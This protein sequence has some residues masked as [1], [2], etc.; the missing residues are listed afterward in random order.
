MDA[1]REYVDETC[2]TALESSYETPGVDTNPGSVESNQSEQLPDKTLATPNVNDS[3]L[4]GQLQITAP[5]KRALQPTQTEVNLDSSSWNSFSRC[6]L[7]EHDNRRCVFLVG[8]EKL[9]NA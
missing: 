2:D 3:H 7:S 6:L 9:V 1:E 8:C 5:S 4:D